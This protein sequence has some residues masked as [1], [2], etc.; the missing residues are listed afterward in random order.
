MIISTG[1]A[2]CTKTFTV[3]WADSYSL[4]DDFIAQKQKGP[5]VSSCGPLFAEIR[6]RQTTPAYSYINHTSSQQVLYSAP[7][8]K[9]QSR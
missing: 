5:N 7:V 3:N 8:S 4:T 1:Y 9:E 6:M 2:S